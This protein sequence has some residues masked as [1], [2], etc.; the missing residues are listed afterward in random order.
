MEGV[1]GEGEKK[2]S[3]YLNRLVFFCVGS[4]ACID[5]SENDCLCREW[6]EMQ[7]KRK[8]R[9]RGKE[10]GSLSTGSL[11]AVTFL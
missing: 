4:T 5:I 7:R 2:K 3:K 10:E 1:G 6:T 8:G 11:A 9:M